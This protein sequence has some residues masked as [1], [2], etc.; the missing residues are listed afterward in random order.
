MMEKVANLEEPV[1]MQI[2]SSINIR[3]KAHS[4]TSDIPEGQEN[5]GLPNF[6][7]LIDKVTVKDTFVSKL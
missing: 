7:H 3:G 4:A 5:R 2:N 1:Q 6:N